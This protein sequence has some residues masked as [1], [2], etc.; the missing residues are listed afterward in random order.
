MGVDHYSAACFKLRD[1]IR[2][3]MAEARS[4]MTVKQIVDVVDSVSGEFQIT[5]SYPK[6]VVP[7][8]KPGF[9]ESLRDILLCK[10]T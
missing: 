3:A 6:P 10:R 8:P 2:K 5:A 4:A 1:S 7:A 9:G